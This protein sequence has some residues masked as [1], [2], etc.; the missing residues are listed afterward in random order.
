MTQSTPTRPDRLRR[1]AILLIEPR[2]HLQLNPAGLFGGGSALEAQMEWLA[3]APHLG[4]EIALTGRELDALGRIGETLWVAFAELARQVPVDVLDGLLE[5]G[6]LIGDGAAHAS[7][8]QRDEK[9]RAVHWKALSAVGHYFS[10]WSED[11]ERGAAAADYTLADIVEKYGLPPPRATERT[12]QDQRIALRARS[13]SGLDELLRKRT[14]CRNFA[15]DRM[16][17]YG[18]FCDMLQRVLGVHASVE[19]HPGVHALKKSNPSGGG[20]HPLEA[21]VLVQNV[22]GVENGLYHYHSPSHSLERLS[23]SGHEDMADVARRFV[24]GQAY[25][26]DAHVLVA[27][28]ARFERTFW[29]YRNHTKAYR[30]I[31]LEAGHVSQNLYLAAAELGLGAYITAAINEVDIESAFGLDPLQE[32][33][34]AVCG[35]GVRAQQKTTTEFD[36]LGEVWPSG[37]AS[38]LE[39]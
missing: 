29:K 14:T 22:A 11:A 1:C 9:V 17:E 21:Y 16:L 30:A 8:R 27:L 5:K 32:S 7:Q 4:S 3:L 25:F 31:V 13:E 38:C 10:R 19:L 23:P 35:F 26:S 34:L 37:I 24:A 39:E 33:P 12:A 20:L 2:E 36:P 15:R 28:V 6:L 18:I